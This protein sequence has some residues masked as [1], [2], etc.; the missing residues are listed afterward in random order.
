MSLGLALWMGFAH[1][2]PGVATRHLCYP[3]GLQ[4]VLSHSV[5]VPVIG[6][7]TTV[8]GGWTDDP[9]G[10]LGLAHLSE[11]LW[12]QEELPGGGRVVDAIQSMGASYNAGTSADHVQ[13][14]VAGQSGDLDALLEL[15][16]RR[17]AAPMRPTEAA[18]EQERAAILHEMRDRGGSATAWFDLLSTRLYQD[19]HPYG[20]GGRTDEAQL[21]AISPDDITAWSTRTFT[22]GNTTLWISGARSLDQLQARVEASLPEDALWT[23]EEKARASCEERPAARAASV[24]DPG[25]TELVEVPADV[26]EPILVFGWTAPPAWTDDDAAWIAVGPKLGGAVRGALAEGRNWSVVRSIAPTCGRVPGAVSSTV[27]CATKL[28]PYQK[29]EAI[30]RSA[31]DDL[32]DHLRVGAAAQYAYAADDTP[33]VREAIARSQLAR[34]TALI[35]SLAPDPQALALKTHQLTV[36]QQGELLRWGEL[37]LPEADALRAYVARWFTEDRVVAAVLVPRTGDDAPDR[38]SV[39]PPREQLRDSVAPAPLDVATPP[40]DA[41][42]REV[43]PNGFTVVLLPTGRAPIAPLSLVVDEGPAAAGIRGRIHHA[44]HWRD[45]SR[46]H[47]RWASVADGRRVGG[48]RLLA[49]ETTRSGW[50]ESMYVLEQVARGEGWDAGLAQDRLKEHRKSA[51][52]TAAEQVQDRI[53]AHLVGPGRA[54]WLG[55]GPGGADVRMR[56]IRGL[57][58][59]LHDPRRATLVVVGDFPP[60]DM[61]AMAREAFGSWTAASRSAP[62]T[63]PEPEGAREPTSIIADDPELGDRAA[64]VAACRTDDARPAVAETARLLV[65]ERLFDRLREAEG[66]T[67]TP[68]VARIDV[69]GEEALLVNV[70]T[71]SRNVGAVRAGIDAALG[72]SVGARELDLARLA[73]AAERGLSLSTRSGLT[74]A[75]VDE[76]DLQTYADD[77]TALTPSMVEA[78]LRGGASDRI[79]A[80]RGPEAMLRTTFP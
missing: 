74:R 68:V 10:R 31:T 70:S 58:A 32:E 16:A 23:G 60:D 27:M 39:A 28:L 53:V 9:E 29:P 22:P 45:R 4:V 78:L 19:D 61:L 37:D 15:E 3:T 57:R 46:R 66:A 51:R 48:K 25:S 69:G 40:L 49:F 52:D 13:F 77:L 72:R 6:I 79:I 47:S 55:H 20:R 33:E 5:D 65:Y 43:L 2:A 1:A 11:H 26:D 64:V 30:L 67:D 34:P 63:G 50:A 80:A 42:R 56:D 76:P 75:L 71:D 24:P 54:A 62:D 7:T 18:V 8:T 44:A 17:L 14:M 38:A 41:L 12:F 59:A 35:S 73:V 21:A 36:H